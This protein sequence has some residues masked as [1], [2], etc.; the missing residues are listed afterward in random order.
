MQGGLPNL[1]PGSR[2]ED[3]ANETDLEGDTSGM[4]AI[5]TWRNAILGGVAAFTLW[6]MV[7]AGWLLLA[8]QLVKDVT[9]DPSNG[10]AVEQ[11]QP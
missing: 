8:D 5:F 6:A 1:R 3:N 10:S 7:A 4:Q 2:A 11:E 9:P